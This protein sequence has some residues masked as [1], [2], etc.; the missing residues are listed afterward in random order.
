MGQTSLVSL[1]NPSGSVNDASSVVELHWSE[2]A[3]LRDVR[4][5][6]HCFH[7]AL[8]RHRRRS[9][10]GSRTRT[11]GGSS[12][13]AAAVVG[14]PPAGVGPKRKWAA[15]VSARAGGRR[16][17]HAPNFIARALKNSGGQRGQR[18]APEQHVSRGHY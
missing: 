9:S 13:G 14:A 10:R 18:Q 4:E 17:A 6:F 12:A 15:A 11:G 3:F 5:G 8:Y 16:T 2:G 1:R 7:D